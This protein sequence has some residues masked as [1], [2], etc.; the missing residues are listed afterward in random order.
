MLSQKM[1]GLEELKRNPGLRKLMLWD[2]EPKRLMEP[3]ITKT[4]AE[5]AKKRF[6]GFVFYIEKISRNKPA[7]YVMFQSKGG[8]AET[9]AHIKEIPLALLEEAVEEGRE[10]QYFGMYPINSRIK[11]WLKKELGISD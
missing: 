5:G 10:R 3:W 2:V 8:Y 7:L 6:T 11:E 1:A 4:E 9:F